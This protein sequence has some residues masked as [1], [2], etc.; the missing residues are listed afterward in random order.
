[1]INSSKIKLND[2]RENKY[3]KR[4]LEEVLSIILLIDNLFTILVILTPNNNTYNSN[5][6]IT[7]KN[8]NLK[9]IFK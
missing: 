7:S 2:S 9:K 6:S 4:I 5:N 3:Y 1:M 8:F